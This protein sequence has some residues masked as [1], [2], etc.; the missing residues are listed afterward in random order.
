MNKT[1]LS[2]IVQVQR[3]EVLAADIVQFDLVDPHGRELPPFTAGAHIDVLAS[4]EHLRQYSLC[5]PPDERHRYRIAVLRE[6]NS[7]GGSVAMHNQVQEGDLLQ[8][9][10]PRNHFA[11]NQDARRTL[12]FAGGIG[13]TPIL[14]MAEALHQRGSDFELHYSASTPGNAA[15]VEYLEA[16]AFADRVTFHFTKT[17]TGKRIDLA[18]QA[19]KPETDVHVYVCGPESFNDAVMDTYKA[20]G[21]PGHQLHT[22]YFVGADVDTSGDGSFE[23]QLA[24]TGARFMIPADKTVAEVLIDHDIDLLTSCEQGI[25]GTCITRVLEGIPEHRDRYMTDEEH[26]AND[27]FTPCCSRSRST[28][29]VLDL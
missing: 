21:W 7:R 29:L 14:A 11:L 3:K 26:A 10:A 2:M 15:F 23:V 6:P 28:R 5:N 1:S 13:I 8:I 17:E 19:A 16:A 4:A 20:A 12:L 25:C 18:A 27:Q 22:E 9:S 24:R